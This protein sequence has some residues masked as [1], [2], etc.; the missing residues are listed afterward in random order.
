[1]LLS[2]LYLPYGTWKEVTCKITE[3]YPIPVIRWYKKLLTDNSPLLIRENKIKSQHWASTLN[4]TGDAGSGTYVCEA[5][6]IYGRSRS[7][8]I[9]TQASSTSGYQ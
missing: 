7:E 9:L 6:N 5:E 1:M 2:E 8:M 3:C 4:V